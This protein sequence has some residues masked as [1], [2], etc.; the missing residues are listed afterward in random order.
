MP[1]V[2]TTMTWLTGVLRYR[3]HTYTTINI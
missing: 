3:I 2:T 1:T